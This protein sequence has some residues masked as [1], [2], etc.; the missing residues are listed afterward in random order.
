MGAMDDILGAGTMNDI[1]GASTMDD[2]LG[3]STMDDILGTAMAAPQS[4]AEAA[5]RQAFAKWTQGKAMTPQETRLVNELWN[6]DPAKASEYWA[7]G[8]FL[9]TEVPGASSLDGGGLDGTMEKKAPDFSWKLKG[10][11]VEL[12]GVTSEHIKYVKRSP[13]SKRIL[14]NSFNSSE[15]K[16][17]LISIAQNAD[18]LKKSGF[19][20]KDIQKLMVGFVP[21]GWQVHHK[22]PL[23]DSGT[24]AFDNLILIRTSP[25]HKVITNYQNYIT[26]G[27]AVG[28]ENEIDWPVLP[29]WIYPM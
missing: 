21:N 25:Y 26:R 14:R 5:Q 20:D 23:D 27:F 19:T 29:G 11:V 8:E 3:A 9:D 22:F 4:A 18:E 2:I 13:E 1:L 24:N 16:Q 10:E 7:A 12:P 6:T 28:S 15:R 17:F